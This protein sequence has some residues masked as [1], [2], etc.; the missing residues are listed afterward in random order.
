M[1]WRNFLTELL[2]GALDLSRARKTFSANAPHLRI[3]LRA[4]N[5]V[6]LNKK[7][8]LNI[9]GVWAYFDSAL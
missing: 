3:N 6:K 2:N 5:T 4:H 8:R 1:R 9:E 7:K